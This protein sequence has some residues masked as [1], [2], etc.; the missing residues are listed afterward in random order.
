VTLLIGV[1]YLA[2]AVSCIFAIQAGWNE[3]LYLPFALFLYNSLKFMLIAVAMFAVA[4][5]MSVYKGH[6]RRKAARTNK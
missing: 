2:L 5:S 6:L 1:A 3:A 4:G